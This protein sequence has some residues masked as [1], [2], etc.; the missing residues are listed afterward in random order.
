MCSR[1][2]DISTQVVLAIARRNFAY[3]RIRIFVC[4]RS[5]YAKPKTKVV[6]AGRGWYDIRYP[7]TYSYSDET[8]AAARGRASTTVLPRLDSAIL[9]M[10]LP[11]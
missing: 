7:R 1:V 11:A 3:D 9:P 5:K 10:D 2:I 4:V 6:A 8:N